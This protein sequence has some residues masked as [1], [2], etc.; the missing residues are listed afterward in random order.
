[1]VD[2]RR[3]LGEINRHL[4]SH[5]RVI[6][7]V[8]EWAAFDS[9]NST[10]DDVYDE[11]GERVYLTPIRVTTLWIN[12]IEADKR[13]DQDRYDVMQNLRGAV[14]LNALRAYGIPDPTADSERVHDLL[15]YRG[16]VW[17]INDWEYIGRLASDD[18]VI[19]F[20]AVEATLG[21]DYPFETPLSI[22]S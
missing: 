22:E 6:G 10:R 14:S 12:K 8:V 17:Q 15:R 13:H 11:P 16:K 21:D 19:G 1:M 5:A 9:T 4:D 20:R 7:E 18:T 3:E 2:P